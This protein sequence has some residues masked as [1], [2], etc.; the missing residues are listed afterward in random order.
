MI[1]YLT[2]LHHNFQGLHLWRVVPP[3]R[4]LAAE[5]LTYLPPHIW[6]EQLRVLSWLDCCMNLPLSPELSRSM[7]PYDSPPMLHHTAQPGK[8]SSLPTS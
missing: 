5:Y 8:S 6:F 2:Y 7:L 1:T 3:H 4:L